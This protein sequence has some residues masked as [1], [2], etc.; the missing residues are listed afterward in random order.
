[1]PILPKKRVTHKALERYNLHTSYVHLFEIFTKGTYGIIY[2]TD[3]M[4]HQSIGEE[5]A[6]SITHGIGFLLS[7]L[8]L[9][10][11]LLTQF[12]KSN[13]WRDIGFCIFAVSLLTMYLMSTLSHSLVFTKARKVFAI[14][15]HSSIFF[16]IA[17]TYSYF[18]LTFFRSSEGLSLLGIVWALCIAGIILKA[19]I[20]DQ[21]RIISLGMY[22]VLGWL[23]L[24][25]IQ[26]LFHV[27]PFPTFLLLILGGVLYSF[28]TIFFLLRKLP[29]SHTIW[30]L[31]VMG[32]S[33]CHLLAVFLL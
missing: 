26:P 31:F 5:I 23:I 7:T 6:N 33:A 15:D 12:D 13:L 17:G 20:V 25:I 21:K 30:H 24:A 2:M 14:L 3:S 10:F 29:F 8:G 16:L 22:V 18:L 28:G 9:I 19:C 4:T 27:L 11:F 1:M 32:G